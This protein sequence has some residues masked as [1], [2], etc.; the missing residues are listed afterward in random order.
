MQAYEIWT[1]KDIESRKWILTDCAFDVEEAAR[2]AEEM[3]TEHPLLLARI[4]PVRMSSAM[5]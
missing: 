1:K 5:H 3:M 2:I 4:E